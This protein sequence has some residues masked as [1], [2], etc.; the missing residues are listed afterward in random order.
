MI[1]NI[2]VLIKK[3]RQKVAG[4]LNIKM[5]TSTLPTAPMPVQTAYA[6]PM[7]KTFVAFISKIMLIAQ[8]IKNPPYQ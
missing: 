7:G 1:E 8:Q 6:V 2:K 3:M 4:S 5:P